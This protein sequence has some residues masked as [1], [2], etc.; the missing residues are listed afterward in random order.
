MYRC[1]LCKGVSKPRQPLHRHAI[2]RL[3][4]SISREL[5]V[6]ERCATRLARGTPLD[7]LAPTPYRTPA[8]PPISPPS[9]RPAVPILV[10]RPAKRF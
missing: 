10:G 6:C 1:E 4:G 2:L 9:V 3:D 8:V 5:V 7:S